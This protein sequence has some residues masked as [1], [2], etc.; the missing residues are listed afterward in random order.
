MASPSLV[1]THAELRPSPRRPWPLVAG[2]LAA[3]AL[4]ALLFL[5]SV[6]ARGDALAFDRTLILA[7]RVSG[8]P[9]LPIGPPKLP[10]IARDV[11]ALGSGTVLT[12]V[13]A[14]A[15]TLLLLRRLWRTAALTLV[16]TIG[17]ASAVSLLK[18]LFERAR[19]DLVE[20]LMRET[21]S[22]FPSGHSANS[23]IVYLTVATLIFP[24]IR[25]THVR[26]FVVVAT[27]TIVGMIGISRVYLGVH[28]PS[29]V[30]AGWIFGALWA[31]GWWR[32]E[33]TLL[34]S[35]RT[36]RSAALG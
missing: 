11:T 9:D 21:S 28:W 10:S 6:I 7:L 30:L 19:P 14:L 32:V 16:A 33:L 13:V 29:D 27:M 4:L 35:A 34:A 31:L 36:A 18:R 20:H 12:L 3:I 24:M 25:E 15:T 1:S 23:A 26:L 22:S 17:G 2:V 8:H 5:A